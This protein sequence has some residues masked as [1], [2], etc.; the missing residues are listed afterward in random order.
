M[1]V[2]SYLSS[3]MPVTVNVRCPDGVTLT[4]VYHLKTRTPVHRLI[5]ATLVDG[6]RQEHFHHNKPGDF[7]VDHWDH[8]K[9]VLNASVRVS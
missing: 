1:D 3:K 4:S 8:S 2:T 5:T 6:G 9:R 7:I